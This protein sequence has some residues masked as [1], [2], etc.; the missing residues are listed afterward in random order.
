DAPNET[1]PTSPERSPLG[2]TSHSRP[3]PATSPKSESQSRPPASSPAKEHRDDA[4]GATRPGSAV[5]APTGE[6]PVLS[7]GDV[8]KAWKQMSI[9]LPKAQANLSALMNSV[10]MID[11]QGK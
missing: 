11:V 10:R 6:K 7:T 8:I 1:S 3:Q 2:G 9:S 4:S 5:E